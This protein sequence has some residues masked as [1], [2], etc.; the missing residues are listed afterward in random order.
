MGVLVKNVE[1]NRYMLF[2]KGADASIL[3]NSTCNSQSKYN[4][5]LKLFSQS[6]WRILAL[7]YKEITK[8]DYKQYD[9]MILNAKNSITE[10][11]KLL[12]DAYER[13]ETDL[14]IVGVTGVEDKLQYGVEETIDSLSQ[15]GI[16][17][18]VLTGDKLETAV[19]IS[20]SCNH[21]SSDMKQI[22]MKNIT[23]KSEIDQF[24]MTTEEKLLI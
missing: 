6:G 12:H 13:I 16:K 23:K 17:I 14:N 10:R 24:L 8:Q 11:D 21:F 3:S 20:E 5:C 22:F 15:A 18:W 1:T 19:K 2:A 4:E 9:R 7:A